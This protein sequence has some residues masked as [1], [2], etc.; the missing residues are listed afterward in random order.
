[1]S[2]G[3]ISG[4]TKRLIME[5]YELRNRVAHVLVKPTIN[6]AQDYAL[7]ADKVIGLIESQ[8]ENLA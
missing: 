4:E 8:A 3:V 1:M 2:S 6:A 5:L 7:A